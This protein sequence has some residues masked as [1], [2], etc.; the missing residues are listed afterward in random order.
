MIWALADFTQS[1]DESHITVKASL[2]GY[3][4]EYIHNETLL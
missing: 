3:Q 4:L 2:N 1:W